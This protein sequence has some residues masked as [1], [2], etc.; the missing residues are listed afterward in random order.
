MG[1]TSYTACA[2]KPE[3]IVM[4]SALDVGN[5]PEEYD[6][7][8]KNI[9]VGINDDIEQKVKNTL[10]G[11]GTGNNGKLSQSSPYR[12]VVLQEI[13]PND[14]VLVSRPRLQTARENDP[15]FMSGFYVDCGL[16]LVTSENIYQK[17]KVPAEILAEDLKRVGINLETGKLIPYNILTYEVDGDSPSG[18]VFK[19]S[20]K[21]KDIAK[22][23]ILNTDDFR[24]DHKPSGSGLFRAF[25]YMDGYWDAD[26][27]YLADSFGVGR[28]V[29]EITS[30]AGSREFETLV[31]QAEEMFERQQQER[32]SL[33]E[34]LSI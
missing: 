6:E 2:T 7:R 31:K 21:G 28:V 12:L 23:L 18:L 27:E 11:F 30:E 29:T 4:C 10:G 13:L 25:L 24:W 17:N 26:S 3:E 22:S 5:Y 9:L 19:L 15:N 33:I 16:N 20:E 34:K 32:L 1:K 14:K 8:V